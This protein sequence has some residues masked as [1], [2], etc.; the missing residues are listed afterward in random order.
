MNGNNENIAAAVRRVTEAARTGSLPAIADVELLVAEAPYFTVGAAALLRHPDA[1]LTDT[2]RRDLMARVALN[3]PDSS[4]LMSLTDRDGAEFAAFYQP[5]DTEETPTTDTAI[6]TF[7]AT[8]GNVDPREAALLERLIFNPVGDYAQMLAREEGA[9][10]APEAPADEQDRLLDAFLDKFTPAESDTQQEETVPQQQ[11]HRTATPRPNAEAPLS[12]SLARVYIRRG[13][14]D[15]AYEI[16]RS[17]SLNYPE[18]SIYFADQL[19][20]LQKLIINQRYK[21]NQ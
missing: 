11:P 19:R 8:Y 6:D 1:Q 15:K 4:A 7:L 2:Q 17:L 21:A 10:D 3:A 16:I 9:A 20:F 12:E 13:R 18:K 5:A 14:Y